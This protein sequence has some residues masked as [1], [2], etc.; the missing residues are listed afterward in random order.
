MVMMR[1]RLTAFALV[2]ILL[3]VAALSATPTYADSVSLSARVLK[4]LQEAQQAMD[5]DQI[6]Q[7]ETLL[8]EVADDQGNTGYDNGMVWFMLGNLHTGNNQL[9]TAIQAFERVFRYDVPPSLRNRTHRL[10]GQVYLQQNQ[11]QK[12]LPHL[13]QWAQNHPEHKADANAL[14]AQCYFQ[15]QEFALASRHLDIAIQDFRAQGKRPKEAWLNLLQASQSQ[16]NSVQGRIRTLHLLL[17][18]FPKKEY[19]LALASANAQLDR[20]DN[21]LAILALA[22]RKDLLNSESQYLSLTGVYL[23]EGAPDNAA[24][25]M[26]QGMKQNRIKPNLRNLRF[27][28][29]ALTMAREYDAALDPLNRATGLDQTGET[30]L[31]LGNA[32][33]QLARWDKAA[34]AFERALEKGNLKDAS[35]AWMMLGQTRLHLKQFEPSLQAFEQAAVDEHIDENKAK[36]VQ[37]WMKYVRYE[38]QRYQ[39]HPTKDSSS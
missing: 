2:C 22:E 29:T 38:Q 36:Q 23:A 19:W 3:A 5:K 30:D 39:A 16:V 21:Y 4:T 34:A 24:R 18:W 6:K 27:L 26:Q 12:A 25:L 37:D 8:I 20:M 15:L 14:L 28:A 13:K 11:Y 31:M 32:L 33:Y 10:I 7:A 35:T 1:S 9:D 17:T